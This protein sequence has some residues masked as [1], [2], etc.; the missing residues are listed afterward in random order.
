MGSEMQKRW[1]QNVVGGAMLSVWMIFCFGGF[2]ALASQ[3]AN[4][5]ARTTCSAVG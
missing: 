1:V 3:L 4:Q 5:L 2:G